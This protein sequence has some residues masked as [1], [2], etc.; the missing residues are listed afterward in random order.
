MTQLL[1][2]LPGLFEEFRRRSLDL[3]FPP[4]CLACEA[5]L[6]SDFWEA[7]GGLLC[8]ACRRQIVLLQEPLC[9]VCASPVPEAGGVRLDC[10]VCRNNKPRFDRT[11]ALGEYEGLLRDLILRMK[12]E[13]RKL[14]ARSLL[15]FAWKERHQELRDLGVDA[16]CAVPTHLI[17]QWQRGVNGPHVLASAL[18]KELGVPFASKLLYRKSNTPPQAGLSRAARSRNIRG[19]ILV[20]N[21]LMKKF[22]HVLLVDDVLTTGATANEC[23]KVLKRAGIARVSVFVL[24][25]TPDLG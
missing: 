16:I 2:R 22:Q 1:D 11:I 13:T 18:S 21:R 8:G 23:A 25:R 6:T 17:R 20:R 9:P 7:E 19:E 14:V 4:T 10:G 3:V 12:S 15:A 24:G 5:D